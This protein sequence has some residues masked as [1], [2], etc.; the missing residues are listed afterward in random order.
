MPHLIDSHSASLLIVDDDIAVIQVLAKTLTQIGRV[1]YALNGVDA[2]RLAMQEPPDVI[3]LDA[4]MPD[5]SGFE[6]LNAMRAQSRLEHVPAIFIT[7]HTG[8]EM[9]EQGLASGAAD[10]IGKPFRPAIV[11][12]RVKTQLRLKL[13]MDRLRK[14]S[15]TD[16]LTGLANRRT[17][18]ESLLIEC[19]RTQRSRNPISVLML[20]VD[21]FKRF[22]DTYGH[23]AG[24]D[25]LTRIA[26]AI[27]TSTNR[28]AD[29]AARYGGEEFVLV[30]PDTDGAGAMTVATTLMAY[31]AQ[32]KIPHIASDTGFLT[33]SIG[34]G[35]FD[36]E[37]DHWAATPVHMR[38]HPDTP[39]PA[40]ATALLGTADQA[41]YAAKEGG[42]ARAVLKRFNGFMPE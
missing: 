27:Q 6:V 42:R 8:E 25:A 16:A 22:N 3:L 9:E 26:R 14:L 35:C 28:P 31:V 40:C 10:F 32:L 29:L 34:I 36:K 18:D 19:K 15:S 23:G 33:I 12:A 39:P 1:R 41:L 37:S 13:A 21:H 20:D 2:L 38:D 5:M 11:A 4:H 7:S 24:D 17:L 30:L